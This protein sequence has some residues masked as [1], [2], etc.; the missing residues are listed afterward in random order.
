MPHATFYTNTFISSRL[1]F[2][3]NVPVATLTD[4]K[5]QPR[6]GPDPALSPVLLSFHTNN[7]TGLQQLTGYSFEHI[8]WCPETSLNHNPILLRFPTLPWN[9]LLQP[10]IDCCLQK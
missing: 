9:H 6:S 10:L 4:Y 7:I 8:L 5:V 2:I 1:T 3:S